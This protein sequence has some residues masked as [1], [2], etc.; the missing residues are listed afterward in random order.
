MRQ[1]GESLNR[2]VVKDVVVDGIYKVSGGGVCRAED[3]AL[4]AVIL[5]RKDEVYQLVEFNALSD[6]V[7]E[8]SRITK[9]EFDADKE[10]ADLLIAWYLKKIDN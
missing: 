1:F 5:A 6:I 10:V 9:R 7:V 3:F 8:Q 2:D 4:G